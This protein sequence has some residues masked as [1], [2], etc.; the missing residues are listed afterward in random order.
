MCDQHDRVIL[1]FLQQV[2]VFVRPN[3]EGMR[4]NIG[5][6]VHVLGVVR[7]STC[8]QSVKGP[9]SV[10]ESGLQ[11]GNHNTRPPQ[12]PEDRHIYCILLICILSQVLKLVPL[13]LVS[14][15]HEL[16]FV[17]FYFNF[18]CDVVTVLL[19]IVDICHFHYIFTH[20]HILARTHKYTCMIS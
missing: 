6:N 10:I 19:I 5:H 8:S 20:A 4:K 17:H 15:H 12:S 16:L 13:L 2:Q 9:S 7:R 1:S 11:T 18:T 14:R 3:A